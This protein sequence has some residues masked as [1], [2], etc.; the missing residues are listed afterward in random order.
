MTPIA[1]NK[2]APRLLNRHL[3]SRRELS[4]KAKAPAAPNIPGSAAEAG[5]QP[6]T[7]HSLAIP[8]TLRR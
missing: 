4:D 3:P 5:A 8:V 1:A 6:T 2:S 7:S